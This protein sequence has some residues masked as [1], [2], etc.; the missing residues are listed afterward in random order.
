MPLTRLFS[1]AFIG[2]EALL[3]EI[4]VDLVLQKNGLIRIV[5]LPDAAVKESKDRVIA[6][7]KNSG[8]TPDAIQCTIHLAPADIKKAGAF[9]DLP[10]SLGILRGLGVFPAQ[11]L[12]NYL[13]GGE[14]GL[15]GEVRPTFGALSLALLAKKLGK[16]GILIPKESA[17]E[18]SMVTGVQVIPVQSLKEAISFFREGSIPPYTPPPFTF[19]GQPGK[20]D[21]SAI[22]GQSHTKR[23]LEI[24]AVGKHNV[25]LSGPPGTG[26]T[27][28]AKAFIGLLPPLQFE[29]ALEIT[30]IHSLA[31]NHFGIVETR[32]FRAPHHTI[33]FVGMVGG[34]ASP[35][36]GE[37][38]LA[39]HGVLFL[40]ELPEFSRSTLEVLRQPL[41]DKVV[42]IS[43]A[44]G[45][46]TFP[47][48]IICIAAMNPCPCGYLG[49]PE[50][51]CR[52]S[53]GQIDRYRGKISGPLLD[54]FDMQLDVPVVRYQDMISPLP[55]ES[56]ET[57]RKRVEEA[58]LRLQSIPQKGIHEL[59]SV[60]KSL[61]KEAVE[62]MGISARA[63]NRI[64][65]VARTIAS[66]AEKNEIC[67][68]HLLEAL[69]YHSK[70][71]S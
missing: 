54:R 7:I 53:Q 31:G 56:S 68:E 43:R 19:K 5:G 28:L 9:Y 35:K 57:I 6:A 62:M 66:L 63:H 34:G 3:V 42:T 18:A 49:H 12:D 65:K 10:I 60:C 36:P 26:K 38:S 40:D 25:L 24:A 47:T 69:S 30:N 16:K 55:E 44:G 70:K 58:S 17:K 8:F 1:A 46:V 67:E 11:E 48:D 14:L 2:L 45:K 13:I 23:A 39:H 37:I 29:E 33:S 21:M 15:G 64:L 59:N 4:E 41:E 27:M 61:M 51:P 22:K 32:P 71:S 52:D 20:V 50:K